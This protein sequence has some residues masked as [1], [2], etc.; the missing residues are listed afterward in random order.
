MEKAAASAAGGDTPEPSARASPLP[1]PSATPSLTPYV[2][3]SVGGHENFDAQADFHLEDQDLPLVPRSEHNTNECP[4]EVSDDVVE[5]QVASSVHGVDVLAWMEQAADAD[6]QEPDQNGGYDGQDQHYSNEGYQDANYPEEEGYGDDASHDPYGGGSGGGGPPGGDPGGDPGGGGNPWENPDDG[7]PSSDDEDDEDDDEERENAN[8][9]KHEHRQQV[10]ERGVEHIQYNDNPGVAEH[11][12]NHGL[13]LDSQLHLDPHPAPFEHHNGLT[14]DYSAYANPQDAA[15]AYQYDESMHEAMQG[16]L[17]GDLENM[18]YMQHPP[19]D[20]SHLNHEQRQELREERKRMREEAERTK[21]RRKKWVLPLEEDAIESERRRKVGND[22]N[23]DREYIRSF[24]LTDIQKKGLSWKMEMQ[25]RAAAKRAEMG[26]VDTPGMTQDL[27]MHE[28]I[29]IPDLP[30][31]GAAEDLP[32]LPGEQP[33]PSTYYHGDPAMDASLIAQGDIAPVDQTADLDSFSDITD[34]EEMDT[35]EREIIKLDTSASAIIGSEVGDE[36]SNDGKLKRNRRPRPPRRFK[37]ALTRIRPK[38]EAAIGPPE[39]RELN[40]DEEGELL[41][42]ERKRR[43]KSV[44]S[45]ALA[46]DD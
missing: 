17:D 18:D 45:C 9:D 4:S 6:Y 16:S 33:G 3:S 41:E 43:K 5:W 8:A 39:Q 2:A 42:Q 46:A 29:A 28:E 23:R 38:L 11:D 44:S 19:E 15:E 32:A 14:T 1:K 37:T 34:L 7:G 26:L 20:E 12:P 40:T 31:F 36:E 13:P 24:S 25:Q 22:A 21:K 27:E 30:E 35:N 10:E